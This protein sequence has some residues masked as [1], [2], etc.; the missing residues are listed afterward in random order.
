[1]ILIK[2]REKELG[3][4]SVRRVLP[5][6]KQHMVGPWIFFD[7]IGPANFDAGQGIN[8]RP[9]PHINLA[10][11]T[12][13]F[14]GEILHRDSLGNTQPITPGAINLMVAGRGIVHSE[15]ETQ[16]THDKPHRIHGLQLWHA[17]PMTDEECEPAF[18]HYPA[19]NIPQ[20]TIYECDI[21]VLIGAAY[22]LHSP[23]KQFCE[24]LYIEAYMPQ[25]AA[26]PLPDAEELAIYIIDGKASCN[27]TITD[28]HHMA[29]IDADASLLVA[30]QDTHCV[31]IGGASLGTRYIEWNFVSSRKERIVQAKEDWLHQRFPSVPGDEQEYIPLPETLK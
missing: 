18:M 7:H 13:L 15:R 27:G 6:R 17:L 22:G 28:T 21:R 4:F 14:D 5:S 26:L 2:G 30:E 29:I 12:Y 20:Q 31:L 16:A 3:E 25:G 11:V 9:H 23:V 10:T 19:D 1:M 8:V 24:T